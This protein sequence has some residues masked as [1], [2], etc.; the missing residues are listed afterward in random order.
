MPRSGAA[1]TARRNASAPA[2]CPAMR[3]SPR[4]V[5]QRPLPS[6]MMAACNPREVLCDIKRSSKKR[7]LQLA[8]GLDQCFH[9]IEIFLQRAASSVGQAILGLRHAALERFC[10][11]DIIGLF[12]LARMYAQVAIGGFEKLL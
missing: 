10:T 4:A 11:G 3:G 2:R 7:D 5:A 1:S 9:M 12:Q 8:H 6:M